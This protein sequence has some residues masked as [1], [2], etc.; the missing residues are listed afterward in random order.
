MRLD[1]GVDERPDLVEVELGGARRVVIDDAVLEPHRAALAAA[2]RR[3]TDVQ[4]EGKDPTKKRELKSVVPPG[5]SSA[6]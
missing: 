5:S 2:P 3:E 6:R 4:T 1:E